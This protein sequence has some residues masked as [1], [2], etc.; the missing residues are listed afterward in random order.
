MP[1]SIGTFGK[2]GI[3]AAS[4][5]TQRLQYANESLLREDE[6]IDGNGIR[7]TRSSDIEMVSDSII[8]VRGPVNLIPTA[9]ELA[10]VLEW[11]MGGTPTGTPTVTYPLADTIPT[12]FV[13]IDRKAKVFTYTGVGVKKATFRAAKGTNLTLQLDLVGMTASA[14][15]NAGT[16]PNLTLDKTTKP[17]V[18]HQLILDVDGTA[19]VSCASFELSVDNMIDEERFFNSQTLTAVNALDRVVMFSTAVPY[20]DYT[21]L[22]A[23]MNAGSG[24]LSATAVFTC[25]GQVLTFSLPAVAIPWKDPETPG[26]VELM[27]PLAGRAYRSGTTDELSIT[28]NP[29]P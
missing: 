26:R 16:F 9:V 14:P 13:T 29:T 24:G 5:V 10:A 6:V 28:L 18:F 1:A 20:G 27:L 2:F 23:A 12:K 7:G 19:N 4:P 11:I 17:W 21:A 25:N 22:H 15:A 8:R 3:G